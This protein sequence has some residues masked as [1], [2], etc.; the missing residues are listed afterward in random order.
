[1]MAMNFIVKGSFRAGRRWEPFT[2]SVEAP[3]ER[4]AVEWTYSLLGSQNGVKRNFVKI[5]SVEEMK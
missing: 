4:V 2:K 1:M 5:E 3:S